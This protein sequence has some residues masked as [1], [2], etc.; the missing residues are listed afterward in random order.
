MDSFSALLFQN[1]PRTQSPRIIPSN[2]L[3]SRPR[4]QGLL[5]WSSV[6]L[7]YCCQKVPKNYLILFPSFEHVSLFLPSYASLC[8]SLCLGSSSSR[9]F[10]ARPRLVVNFS[11][12]RSLS[13]RGHPCPAR[14]QQ[15]R[16]PRGPAALPS[17]PEPLPA[18]HTSKREI[19]LFCFCFSC[20]IWAPHVGGGWEPGFSLFVSPNPG[21][22]LGTL[23]PLNRHL[24]NEWMH[25]ELQSQCS[26]PVSLEIRF[27]CLCFMPLSANER[28]SGYKGLSYLGLNQPPSSHMSYSHFLFCLPGGQWEMK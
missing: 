10:H 5:L 27:F 16:S 12:Q 21:T 28:L 19:I 8:S 20:C 17:A 6:N 11:A 13:H 2:T 9:S 25:L 18:P 1:L 26:I 3:S 23:E 4:P 22:V 7:I 15:L 14:L 24:L